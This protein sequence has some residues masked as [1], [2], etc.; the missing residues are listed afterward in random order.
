MAVAHIARHTAVTPR[1]IP[2]WT[3][4]GGISVGLLFLLASRLEQKWFLMLFLGSLVLT[5]SLAFADKKAYYLALLVGSLPLGVDVNLYFHPSSV[6]HSTYGFL[7]RLSSVPLALLYLRWLA[8]CLTRKLPLRIAPTG[9]FPLTGFFLSACVSL[10]F[11]KSFLFGAFD[12]FALA[13][14]IFLFVYAASEVRETKEVRLVLAVLIASV[15]LQG[16]I[17]LGQHATESTLGLDFFGAF[18][19]LQS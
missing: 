14:S 6:S 5:A 13:L 17:A 19:N 12:L 3:I 15:A 9:L 10:F 11:A 2:S 7:V 1:G 8:V 4:P 16:V 18:R